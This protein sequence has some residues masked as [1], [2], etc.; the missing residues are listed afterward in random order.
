M[1]R[2][3]KGHGIAVYVKGYAGLLSLTP[4]I[5]YSFAMTLITDNESLQ[6]FC[7]DVSTNARYVTVDTEF[8][9]EKTY[10]PELCLIQ[11]GGENE[12]AAIDAQADGID[13]TP[14]FDLMR[15][16]DIIKVFHAARQDFEIFYQLMGEIPSPVFDTQVSA[17]VCGFGESVGY[18]ALVGSLARKRI[19]KSMRFTDW[20]RR[21]LS[22]KQLDYALSDVTHLRVVYEK[23]CDMLAE[24]GRESWVA[25]EM[26]ALVDP[27]IYDTD[28][29]DAWKRLKVRTPKP[30]FLA[31][32]REIAAWRETEARNRNVPRN[33]VLRDDAVL[34]IAA[35]AP[36]SFKSL[37]S[38]RGLRGGQANG[39]NGDAILAAIERGKAI[40]EDQC[41]V[42]PERPKRGSQKEAARELVKV[43]LKHCAEEF[44]VAQRLI[45]NSDELEMLIDDQNA[46]IRALKGW[47]REMFGNDAIDLISG[48]VALT[49]QDSKIKLIRPGG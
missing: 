44:G 30:R 32:L 8:I 9:R 10:W 27:A 2:G 45:A 35:Q 21:P 42:A 47:R 43:L 29:Q 46:D 41:P 36:S 48:K 12:A 25:E 19:D 11:I 38:L 16:Q 7:K 15:N 26:A 4:L 33:R 31:I 17:M 3:G 13:L 18:E 1:S 5:V 6:Q 24:N 49:A 14:V 28:P 37:S 23:L 39:K 20:S 40:P 34:E 22:D